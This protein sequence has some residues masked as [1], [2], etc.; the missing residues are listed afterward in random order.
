MH[1]ELHTQTTL[2]HC[3][4]VCVITLKMHHP[5]TISGTSM[6]WTMIKSLKLDSPE[7]LQVRTSVGTVT[8]SVDSFDSLV[9]LHVY[10]SLDLDSP[11]A[12]LSVW[13]SLDSSEELTRLDL[14]SP[15]ELQAWVILDIQVSLHVN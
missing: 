15:S 7:K 9:E 12:S 11:E 2:P 10:M 1:D 3:Q 13:M 14:H 5:P 8:S 4:K 6:I